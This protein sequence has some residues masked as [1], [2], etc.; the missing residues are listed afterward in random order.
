[1]NK[2]LRWKLILAFVLVFLAGAVCGFFGAMHGGRWIFVHAHSGSLA[3]HMKRQLQWE[4]RL[5]PEQ[6]RQISPIIDRATSQLQ[7]KREQTMRDVRNIFEETH[8]EMQP[9]LSPEQRS[10]LEQIEQRHRRM[11]HHHGFMPPAG[12]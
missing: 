7:A 12:D 1:M 2:S 8:R 6:V 10:K 4:L 3:E 5:T 9:F 11:L